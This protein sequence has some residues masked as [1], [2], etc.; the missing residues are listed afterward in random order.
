MEGTTVPLGAL[1]RHE[2]GCETGGVSHGVSLLE[3]HIT[4]TT[5]RPSSP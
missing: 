1:Q 4:L 5:R 3:L 2:R